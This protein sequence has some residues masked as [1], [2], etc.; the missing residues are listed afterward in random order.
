MQSAINLFGSA[1][2]AAFTAAWR[3]QNILTQGMI[4]MGQTMAAFCGQNFG[5]RK[6]GRMRACVQTGFL[7]SAS[8]AV[9]IGALFILLRRMLLGLFLV[10]ANTIEIGVSIM[11]AEVP[12]YLAWVPIEIISGTCRSAGEAV[13]PM[14][15]TACGIC[16]LRILWLIL[17][18][19]KWHE[20]TVLAASYPFTWAMTSII[21][22]VYYKSMKWL[23]NH[24]PEDIRPEEAL[25]QY[26]SGGIGRSA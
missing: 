8:G 11:M 9:V 13:R 25:R 18:M 5:A 17:V 24:L 12:F 3:I 2:V 22:F 14:L 6:Y 4:A 15:I 26:R 21:F 7:M 20:A 16:L 23:T 10:D 19:P 1:A